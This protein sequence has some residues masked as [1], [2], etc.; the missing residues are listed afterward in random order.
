LI[1][2]IVYLSICLFLVPQVHEELLSVGKP[3]RYKKAIQTTSGKL[4]S[5]VVLQSLTRT[6]RKQ[7]VIGDTYLVEKEHYEEAMNTVFSNLL[8]R[9][10]ICLTFT[11]IQTTSNHDPPE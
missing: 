4:I 2:E 3:E 8:V 10:T 7:G 9:H 11:R 1:E 6:E 5:D